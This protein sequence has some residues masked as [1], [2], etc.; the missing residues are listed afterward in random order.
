MPLK[1]KPFLRLPLQQ[2][3][4]NADSATFQHLGCN[5]PWFG[6]TQQ[7]LVPAQEFNAGA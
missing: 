1:P 3:V 6:T 7:E 2:S 4:I 5:V